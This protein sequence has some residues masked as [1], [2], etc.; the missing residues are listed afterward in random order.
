MVRPSD[1]PRGLGLL[2]LLSSTSCLG[3]P[4]FMGEPEPDDDDA[5]AGTTEDPPTTVTLTGVDSTTQGPATS[6]TTGPP[7][8]T[9]TPPPPPMTTVGPPD[10]GGGPQFEVCHDYE[11]LIVTCYGGKYQGE[12][13]GYCVEYLS[14]AFESYPECYPLLEEFFVCISSL[15]CEQLQQGADECFELYNAFD[16][17]RFGQ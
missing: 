17:C 1:D 12:L 13:Y 4:R 9:T 5:T 6:T 8:P 14:Y 2:L 16:E 10:L 15:T 7:P 3:L 11:D